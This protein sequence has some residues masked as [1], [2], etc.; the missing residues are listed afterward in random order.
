VPEVFE[1]IVGLVVVS[2]CKFLPRMTDSAFVC[3]FF[4]AD[5]K[6]DPAGIFNRFS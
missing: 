1:L 3:G 6:R 5:S 2:H 4:V